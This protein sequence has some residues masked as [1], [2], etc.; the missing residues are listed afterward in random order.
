M[1]EL[2]PLRAEGILKCYELT[3]ETKAY[4]Q[5]HMCRGLTV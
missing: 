5:I 3:N 1:H 2:Q 4:G